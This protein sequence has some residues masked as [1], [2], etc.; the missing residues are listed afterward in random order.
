MIKKEHCCF[1]FLCPSVIAGQ[2]SLWL[3]EKA[4]TLFSC[5][6][7]PSPFVIQRILF[8]FPSWRAFWQSHPTPPIICDSPLCCILLVVGGLGFCALSKALVCFLWCSHLFYV[9]KPTLSLDPFSAILH[10]FPNNTREPIWQT[11]AHHWAVAFR[12][13]VTVTSMWEHS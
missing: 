1:F 9:P 8:V 2:P 5:S 10:S 4:W 11:A 3:C 13:L 12:E 6:L 7:S